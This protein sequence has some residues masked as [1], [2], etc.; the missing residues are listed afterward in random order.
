M[1]SEYVSNRYAQNM[2]FAKLPITFGKYMQQEKRQECFWNWADSKVWLLFFNNTQKMA[3]TKHH[4]RFCP[5]W[6]N[7]LCVLAVQTES[8]G[9]NWIYST[10]ICKYERKENKRKKNYWNMSNN[11]SFCW[12]VNKYFEEIEYA[13]AVYPIQLSLYLL[14]II[15]SILASICS[16][17]QKSKSCLKI[18]IPWVEKCTTNTNIKSTDSIPCQPRLN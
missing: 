15:C 5:K 6:Y 8:S 3:Y 1:C 13:R 14:I 17:K 12:C 16:M 7:I 9:C 4:S 18:F 11:G 2:T 10:M